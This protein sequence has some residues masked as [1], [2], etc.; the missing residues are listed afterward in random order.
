MGFR[1]YANLQEENFLTGEH[2]YY[3]IRLK[4]DDLKWVIS[5]HNKMY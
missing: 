2:N 4:V 3:Q 1:M 5:H